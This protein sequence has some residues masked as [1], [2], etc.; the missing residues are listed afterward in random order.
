MFNQRERMALICLVV[1]LLVGVATTWFAQ[2][3]P[4][5]LENFRVERAAV[6][7]PPSGPVSRHIDLN[8]ASIEQL[9]RLP[10]IGEKMA[11]RI[12]EYRSV[13]GPFQTV[14]QLLQVKGIGAVR[15]EKIAPFLRVR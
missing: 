6:T 7:V 4:E 2:W 9:D 14:Q 1:A 3:Q 5:A 8:A 10:S 11:K 12:V 15:L 13:N